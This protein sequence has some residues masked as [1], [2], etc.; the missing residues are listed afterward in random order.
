MISFH[1]IDT[2]PYHHSTKNFPR[3]LYILQIVAIKY[4]Y[5]WRQLLSQFYQV[6]S[7]E[8]TIF[9][10]YIFG[11]PCI[12]VKVIYKSYTDFKIEIKVGKYEC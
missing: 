2:M 6:V 5:C 7:S 1:T 8:T 3:I 11:M 9:E 10:Q 12:L 4:F